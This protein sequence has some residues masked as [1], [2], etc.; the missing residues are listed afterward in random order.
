MIYAEN[1]FLCIVVPLI[2]SL[3]FVS[4]PARNF[5]LSFLVGMGVCL[6]GA[7]I[8]GFLTVVSGMTAEEVS[9]YLSPIVEEIVKLLPLLFYLYV[10]SPDDESAFLSAIAIGVG[11]ATF[12]NCCY[13][14]TA[15]AESLTYTLIRGLAVG[16]MH[17]VSMLVLA[18]GLVLI[19]RFKVV[20]LAGIVGVLALSMVFH[21]L[22]NLLVSQP[23]VTSTIGYILPLATAALLYLPFKRLMGSKR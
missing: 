19:R 9:I 8:S 17:V 6:L 1:I 5:V 18:L 13:I 16:V 3:V 22:Y 23:G 11:F 15:G 21:A 14:L 2:V 20:S 7:Y 10:F 12:E 4:G